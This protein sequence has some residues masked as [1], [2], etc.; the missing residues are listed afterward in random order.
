MREREPEGP[1]A[2]QL[3]GRHGDSSK[4]RYT[5]RKVKKKSEGKR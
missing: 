5:G 4:A 3:P 1:E 2:G